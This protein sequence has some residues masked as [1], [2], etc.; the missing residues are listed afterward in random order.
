MPLQDESVGADLKGLEPL[1]AHANSSV[2][3]GLKKRK[4]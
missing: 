3:P 4:L 2:Q 1:L